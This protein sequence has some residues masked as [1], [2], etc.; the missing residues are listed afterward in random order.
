MIRFPYGDYTKELSALTERPCIFWDVD[1]LDW[2]SMNAQAVVDK[3]STSL[4]GGDIVLMHDVYESTVEACATLIP[5]LQSRGYELVNIQELAAANG[6]EL[7]PGVT[8]FGF[9]TYEKE[10]GTVTDQGRE[11]ET[12]PGSLIKK[13]SHESIGQD[14]VFHEIF[15]F[16]RKPF[17]LPIE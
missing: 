3:V 5:Q 9:T 10:K 8:Y 11:V 4:D 12:K 6:Y 2:D 17:G 13:K 16:Y 15:L 14:P 1:S 7:E